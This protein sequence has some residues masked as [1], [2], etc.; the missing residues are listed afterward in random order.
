MRGLIREAIL[1]GAAS[2]LALATDVGLLWTLV[3]QFGANYLVAATIAFLAGTTVVYLLSVSTIFSHRRIRDRRAEFTAFSA[4]GVLGL[5]VNLTVMLI[6]VDGL[7]GHYLLGKIASVFFTFSLNF[8]LRR[9]LLF[10]APA[11]NGEAQGPGE[12][13][14]CTRLP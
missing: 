3:E 12:S 10:S 13:T 7:G 6:V 2:A 11:Q 14:R 5:G 9:Y 8:G 4:I 1:Y